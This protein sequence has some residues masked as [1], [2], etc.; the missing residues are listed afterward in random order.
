MIT[1]EVAAHQGDEWCTTLRQ[2]PDTLVVET[3][4]VGRRAKPKMVTSGAQRK[5]H[6]V[7]HAQCHRGNVPRCQTTDSLSYRRQQLAR[8][9]GHVQCLVGA[10]L[11][12]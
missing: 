9:D 8:G 2:E 7:E 10:A 12:D 11:V 3:K 5:P 1:E 6:G 4:I